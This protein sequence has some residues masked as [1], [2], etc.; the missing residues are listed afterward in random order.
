LRLIDIAKRP[1]PGT[2]RGWEQMDSNPASPQYPTP[3]I[4]FFAA[5]IFRLLRLIACLLSVYVSGVF[6]ARLTFSSCV[7]IRYDLPIAI[8]FT[9]TLCYLPIPY[10]PERRIFAS[11]ATSRGYATSHTILLDLRSIT[12][13]RNN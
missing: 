1:S 2:E 10:L 11:N 7:R 5:I 4:L 12:D 3:E 13:D 8:A 6:S 9:K